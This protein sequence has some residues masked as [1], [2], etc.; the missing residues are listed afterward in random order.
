[1]ENDKQGKVDNLDMNK[2]PALKDQASGK[3]GEVRQEE[4]KG[5]EARDI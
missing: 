2:V 5:K 1:M 4:E 3:M